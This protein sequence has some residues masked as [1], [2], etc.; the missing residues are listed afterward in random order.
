GA[1]FGREQPPAEVEER[2]VSVLEVLA[3][4]AAFDVSGDADILDAQSGQRTDANRTAECHA[5]ANAVGQIVQLKRGPSQRS[6]QVF[7][8]PDVRATAAGAFAD[9]DERANPVVHE[10]RG[11]QVSR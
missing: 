11:E 4:Q 7:G 3:C 5:E 2:R 8:K 10:S 6:D 9:R 1:L